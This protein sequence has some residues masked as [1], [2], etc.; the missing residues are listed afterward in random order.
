MGAS[1]VGRGFT[2]YISNTCMLRLSEGDILACLLVCLLASATAPK[3]PRSSYETNGS[4]VIGQGTAMQG[5]GMTGRA[6]STRM[7]FRPRPWFELWAIRSLS[8][9]LGMCFDVN[10][11]QTWALAMYRR[12]EKG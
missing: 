10:Q 1:L 6:G 5:T 3:R 8:M 2:Y 7:I 9:K 12:R 11:Y 4:T